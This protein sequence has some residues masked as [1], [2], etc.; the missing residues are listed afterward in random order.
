MSKLIIP[1]AIN[2]CSL[3][4]P[5]CERKV[6]AVI[7]MPHNGMARKSLEKYLKAGDTKN[8]QRQVDA[9]IIEIYKP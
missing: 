3:G 5:E 8:I 4:S 6:K 2:T 1:K 7:I 9:G